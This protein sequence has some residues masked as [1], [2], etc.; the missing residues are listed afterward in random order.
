[1]HVP[2]TIRTM[3]G[4]SHVPTRRP[5]LTVRLAPS[6][7]QRLAHMLETDAIRAEQEGRWD[8]AET[9]AWRAADLREAAR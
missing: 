6:D 7:K 8:Q 2:S 3:F 9:L 4:P 5:M 1:M